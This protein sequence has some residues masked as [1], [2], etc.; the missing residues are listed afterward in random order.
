MV[1][2]CQEVAISK[3]RK[4]RN[5]KNASS[6]YQDINEARKELGG[7]GLDEEW[8]QLSCVPDTAASMEAYSWLYQFISLTGNY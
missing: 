7:F 5:L 3:V 4:L 8:L 2:G 1:S 6:P